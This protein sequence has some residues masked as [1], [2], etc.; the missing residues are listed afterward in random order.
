[1][2]LTYYPDYSVAALLQTFGS[3]TYCSPGQNSHL[4]NWGKQVFSE[5]RLHSTMDHTHFKF[6]FLC[7][8]T[9]FRMILYFFF[10]CFEISLHVSKCTFV[11]EVQ[12]LTYQSEVY[13]LIL[14]RTE[15]PSLYEQ[16]RHN[17]TK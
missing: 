11:K 10:V 8:E 1:M 4:L 3:N 16:S 14:F 5:E 6:F 12:F 13:L 7:I 9:P 15:M 17:N 2:L